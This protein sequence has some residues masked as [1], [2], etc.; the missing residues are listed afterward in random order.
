M[1][2]FLIAITIAASA[3]YSHSAIAAYTQQTGAQ[4]V[5]R[6]EMDF[7]ELDMPA[8]QGAPKLG[9][10]NMVRGTTKP[11]LTE[12]HG[13]AAPALW[14]WNQ[15]GKLDLLIGEFETCT[16]D[17]GFPGGEE[18]GS[19]IRVYLNQGTPGSPNFTD[20][21]VYAKD[22]EGAVIEVPQW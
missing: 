2:K 4:E 8:I 13:L 11:I 21:F 10:L 22:T 20:E 7:P 19:G 12:K 3:S 6:G 15:D 16:K 17:N 18:N 5:Q 9:P 14:D 1:K